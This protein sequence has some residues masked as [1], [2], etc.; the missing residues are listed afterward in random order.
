MDCAQ[1][2]AWLLAL[3]W[4]E[5]LTI[6]ADEFSGR[7]EC[8]PCMRPPGYQCSATTVAGMACPGLVLSSSGTVMS[9]FGAAQKDTSGKYEECLA[10]LGTMQQ[11]R[12]GA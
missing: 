6:R 10:K 11:C 2:P 8:Y 12:L 5:F 3:T 1:V 9:G 7:L 4:Q